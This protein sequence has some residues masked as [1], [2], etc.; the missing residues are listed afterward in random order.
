MKNQFK[1]Y[2]KIFIL[3]FGV[4][5]LLLNCEKEENIIEIQ[6]TTN[7]KAYRF[8]NDDI[9]QIASK[10]EQLSRQEVFTKSSGSDSNAYWVDDVNIFGT[11]DSVGNKSFSYRLYFNNMPKNVFYNII[12]T[13]RVSN[14]IVPFVIAFEIENNEKKSIRYYELEYFLDALTKRD[15][16]NKT[17]SFLKNDETD[18][19]ILDFTDCGYLTDGSSGGDSSTGSGSGGT[20]SA[21]DPNA[22][23]S[24]GNY[25][26]YGSYTVY[27]YD[28]GGGGSNVTIEVGEGVLEFP[29]IAKSGEEDRVICPEGEVIIVENVVKIIDNLE[30]KAK[31][32]YEKLQELSEGFSNSIKKFDGDFPVS[33]LTFNINNSLPDGNYGRTLAPVNYNITIEMSNTQLGKISD[34]GGAVSFAHEV[35]HAEIYRKMLSAAQTGN[36]DP[37]NMTQEQ[38]VNYVESLRDNFPGLYDYYYERHQPTWNHDMMAQHYISTI[39]DIAQ[40][41]DNSNLSRQV[42]E[43]IAW[44]GLR[45]LEDMNNSVAWDNLSPTEQQRI[46][47]NLSNTFINGSS[48]C[49]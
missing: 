42:Y 16:K 25:T 35:I 30:G 5:L 33:H 36:L 34:I 23:S 17:G 6:T 15:E 12:I 31:C 22:L 19:G 3:F 29:S 24:S 49:N 28:G 4:S 41:F 27:Y 26:S 18:N 45:V 11:I 8:D 44:A 47:N 21:S 38:Q 10:I 7:F 14:E 9:P 39:A 43:D 1:N 46:T 13:E 48:N 37:D 32:V 20:G 40:E 2:F